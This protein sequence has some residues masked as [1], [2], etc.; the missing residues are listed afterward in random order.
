[1][2]DDEDR[3][4]KSDVFARP[5]DDE[6][7]RLSVDELQGRITWLEEEIVRTKDILRGKEGAFSDA[8]AAV[9]K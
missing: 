1:M 8:Q 9:K 6:L 7:N 4:A 5:S 2:M 3:A